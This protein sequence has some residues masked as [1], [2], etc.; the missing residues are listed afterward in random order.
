MQIRETPWGQGARCVLLPTTP[1]TITKHAAGVSMPDELPQ[2][3]IPR[4]RFSLLLYV[5]AKR[6]PEPRSTSDGVFRRV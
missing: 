2:R 6:I 3:L 4:W 5:K 1:L